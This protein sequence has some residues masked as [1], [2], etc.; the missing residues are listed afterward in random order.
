MLVEAHGHPHGERELA[1][2]KPLHAPAFNWV[3]RLRCLLQSQEEGL[4]S[5]I[6]TAQ[7]IGSL[8]GKATSLRSHSKEVAEPELITLY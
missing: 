6:F 5:P 2:T 7:D 4:K 3:L 8:R 1:L